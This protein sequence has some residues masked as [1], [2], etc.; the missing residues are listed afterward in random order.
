MS[1]EDQRR[2]RESYERMIELI[3]AG[4]T[5]L[6]AGNSLGRFRRGDEAAAAQALE[7]FTQKERDDLHHWARWLLGFT[8]GD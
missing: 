4:S 6:A 1:I 5:S 7:R 8:E 2:M 3:R